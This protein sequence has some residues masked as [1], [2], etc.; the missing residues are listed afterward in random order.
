MDFLE[1]FKLRKDVQPSVAAGKVQD[2][3]F[4]VDF[5][6]DGRAFLRVTDAEGNEVHADYRLY[7]GDTFLLL[8]SLGSIEEKNRGRI[9]WGAPG[10]RVYFDENPHLV[11]QLVRCAHV[12]DHDLH[13]L[14]SALGRF[15]VVLK[16]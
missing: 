6:P 7:Q 10:E 1:R 9:S 16:A 3:R 12:V 11:Y 15:S 14:E 4:L 8:R 2:I 5:D 13:P